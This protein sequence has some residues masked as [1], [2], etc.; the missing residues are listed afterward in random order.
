[1]GGAEVAVI[2]GLHQSIG[3]PF[4]LVYLFRRLKCVHVYEIV[5]HGRQWWFTLHMST[6]TRYCLR[7]MQP[8]VDPRVR[9]YPDWWVYGAGKPYPAGVTDYLCDNLDASGSYRH[10]SV[11]IVRDV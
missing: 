8:S 7:E 2:L 6:D 4:K 1:M 10:N 3:G 11:L 5:S 9:Q